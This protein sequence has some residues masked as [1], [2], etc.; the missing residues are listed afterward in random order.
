[1]D[2]EKAFDRVMKEVVWW[3]LRKLGIKEW[4]VKGVM[5]MYANA[6]TVVKTKLGNRCGC[7]YMRDPLLFVA[8]IV[9]LIFEAGQVL[10]WDLL[11]VV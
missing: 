5:T 3:A 10:P 4:L 8:V 1:M 6:R 9:A 11:Y 2:L 7:G